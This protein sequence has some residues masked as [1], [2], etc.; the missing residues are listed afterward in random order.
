M[1][2][3]LFKS[4]TS[5]FT[6]YRSSVSLAILSDLLFLVVSVFELGSRYTGKYISPFIHHTKKYV[7]VGPM[8]LTIFSVYLVY[9]ETILGLFIWSIG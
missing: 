2:V 8:H 9:Y 4:R 3:F 6:F 1:P 7:Y 5:I